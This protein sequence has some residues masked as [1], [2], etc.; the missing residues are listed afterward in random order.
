[1]SRAKTS[2]SYDVNGKPY[3]VKAVLDQLTLA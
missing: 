2:A 3:K 1:M